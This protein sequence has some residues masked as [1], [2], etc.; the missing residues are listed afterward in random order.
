MDRRIKRLRSRRDGQRGSLKKNELKRG[1]AQEEREQ[2]SENDVTKKSSRGYKNGYS[3]LVL[4]H[5]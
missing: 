4:Q 3:Y 1:R 2:E 5:S